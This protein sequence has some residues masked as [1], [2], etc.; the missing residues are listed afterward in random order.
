M[1]G[2]PIIDSHIHLYPEA[3]MPT[4]A[5]LKPDHPL[6]SEHSVTEYASAAGSC[7]SLKGYILVETDR[8][9]QLTEEGWKYPL[10][11]VAWMSRVATGNA[12]EEEDFTPEDAKKCLAIIP[13]APVPSGPE[14]LEKYLAKVEEAAGDA[15]GKVKG[16]RY[17]LQ[18][19]PGGTMLT[20]EFVGGI[21]YLGKRGFIFE[22]GVDQHRRG[23]KQLDELVE[24]ISRAHEDVP[25]EEKVT[26]IINHMCKPDL[27]IYNLSDKGFT[28]WRTAIY[29]LS[30]CEK[31]FI[32]LSGGFS[33]MTDSLKNQSPDEIFEAIFPWFGILLATIGAEK[34]IFGSDWPIST[35]GV[36]GN[37][38]EKWHGVVNRMCYMASLTEEKQKLLY[39][40]NAIKAFNL[41]V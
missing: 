28:N 25:D 18:D 16:F 12:L 35:V 6:A 40:E 37:A 23:K 39:A 14:A 33:E 8:K 15:W 41:D 3:E 13:W 19:K 5:W 7:K 9:Q 10:V 2:I 38:W 24:L 30:R 1:A 36:E 34:L 21:K 27:T 26:F 32:Q 31:T 17:L 11:E 29:T 4:L 20:E 22:V